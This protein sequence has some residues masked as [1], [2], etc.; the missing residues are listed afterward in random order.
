MN[1]LEMKLQEI[2]G[3]VVRMLSHVKE[4]VELARQ[5]LIYADPEAA[6]RC[7]E[8]DRRVGLIQDQLERDILTLIARRQ[9][10]AS[11]LR[12][13]AAMYR[14]LADIERAGN[15][16]EHVA[17]AG[18]ELATSPPLKK[19][20]DL[21]RVFDVIVAMIEETI[22]ALAESDVQAARRAHVM[23]DEIDDLYQQVQRELLTY[24]M[25]DPKTISR[26]TKLLNVGRYLERLGDHFENVNEHII[27]WLTGERL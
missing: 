10:A 25:E 13:L 6:A 15:Y 12:F 26:A 1:M 8:N 21:A 11:D 3:E 23:D 22:K 2:N 27:F 19:Y 7:T 17:R 16:A 4:S 14:A 9:P 24:M 5:A 20:L 18:A